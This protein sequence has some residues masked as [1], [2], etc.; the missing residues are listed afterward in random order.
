[1]GEV[2]ECDEIDSAGREKVIMPQRGELLNS[3]T[4]EIEKMGLVHKYRAWLLDY[5][6]IRVLKNRMSCHLRWF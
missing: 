3:V 2:T 1:M 5:S 4:L 6:H